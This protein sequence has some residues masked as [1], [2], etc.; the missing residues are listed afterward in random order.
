MA[1]HRT[2]KQS[3]LEKRFKHLEFQLYGK[4]SDG[5]DKIRSNQK[6]SDSVNQ[7]T[8]SLISTD[9]LTHR[10]TDIQIS[11]GS[12]KTDVTYLRHDLTKILVFSSVA[13]GV[14]VLLYLGLVNHLLKIPF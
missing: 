14:Q 4:S 10:S 13:V 3:D 12:P 9:R 5:S 8:H 7:K 11:S 2:K 1:V 6:T